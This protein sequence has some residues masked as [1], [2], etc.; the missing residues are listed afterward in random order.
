MSSSSSAADL[1]QQVQAALTRLLGVSSAFKDLQPGKDT[2]VSTREETIAMMQHYLQRLQLVNVVD[3]SSPR[4]LSVVH[5]AGTKGKGS[6]CAMVER[7]LRQAGYKT[8]LFTSPH[9]VSPWT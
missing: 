3:S 4:A 6:T 9:L 2:Q 1:S 5:V 7:I 8:G